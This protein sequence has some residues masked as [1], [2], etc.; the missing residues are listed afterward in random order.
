MVNTF[1]NIYHDPTF[2][3]VFAEESQKSK[4]ERDIQLWV[5][6]GSLTFQITF[7]H[8]RSLSVTLPMLEEKAEKGAI[9]YKRYPR[10]IYLSNLNWMMS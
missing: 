6:V 7:G 1:L 10:K 5:I 2:Q 8:S 3:I 4:T 9:Q